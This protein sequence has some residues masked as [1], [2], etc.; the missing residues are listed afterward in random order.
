MVCFSGLGERTALSGRGGSFGELVL[1]KSLFDDEGPRRAPT[2]ALK[3]TS[4][5]VR[6]GSEGLLGIEG[7]ES[8]E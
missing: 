6:A 5:D 2:L 4:D 1:C 8:S 3:P 7:R